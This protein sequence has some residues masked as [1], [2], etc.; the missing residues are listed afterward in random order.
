MGSGIRKVIDIGCILV[1]FTISLPLQ[2]YAQTSQELRRQACEKIYELIMQ[3][4]A[5][6][7]DSESNCNAMS[8]M[9]SSNQTRELLSQ[10]KPDGAT[11]AMMNQKLLQVADMCKVA[12]QKAKERKPYKSAQEWID[13]GG[14]TL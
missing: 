4:Q 9:L 8:E 13:S 14:C 3:C 2:G 6:A 10:N 7:V 11:D 1:V 5:L 12:C